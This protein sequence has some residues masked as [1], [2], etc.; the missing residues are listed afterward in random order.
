MKTRERRRGGMRWNRVNVDLWG[1]KSIR[2][3][4]IRRISPY[5]VSMETPID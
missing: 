2:N 4:N 3:V 5:Y 1:P